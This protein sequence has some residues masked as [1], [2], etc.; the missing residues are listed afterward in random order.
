MRL[1]LRKDGGQKSSITCSFT[2]FTLFS[3]S[4]EDRFQDWHL[5]R[6]ALYAKH[7]F[8]CTE[9][10]NGPSPVGTAASVLISDS[11]LFLCL[12]IS[13]CASHR[14]ERSC[15]QKCYYSF[16]HGYWWRAEKKQTATSSGSLK[17]YEHNLCSKWTA[18]TSLCTH[19]KG[20]RM[21]TVTHGRM[22]QDWTHGHLIITVWKNN[23]KGFLSGVQRIK[24]FR[25]H[26]DIYSV[27]LWL[28]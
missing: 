23:T 1:F 25:Y 20:G 22:R 12:I 17:T 3:H 9:E 16:H 27:T 7:P 4:G 2:L 24:M 26:N 13:T 8:C 6:R 28:V 5:Q 10:Q 15:A 14:E 21:W 19:P 18:R 11:Q